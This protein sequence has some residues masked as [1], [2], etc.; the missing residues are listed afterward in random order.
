MDTV[1][2]LNVGGTH[3]STTVATLSSFP[4]VLKDIVEGLVVCQRDQ[5][6]R[7]FVDSDGTHFGYIL[8]FLRHGTFALPDSF[9][10]YGALHQSVAHLLPTLPRFK[11]PVP[12]IG[13]P[14]S[15]GM[16]SPEAH[17][18][19]SPSS[20]L[21]HTPSPRRGAGGAGAVSPLSPPYANVGFQL[22]KVEHLLK[23]M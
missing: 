13:S 10:S 1:V 4:G 18:P 21:M 22:L 7:I 19:H 2:Q 16:G 20:L 6:G 3:H 12:A 17:S 9:D 23:Q 15:R 14:H 5:D 11:Y 8:N